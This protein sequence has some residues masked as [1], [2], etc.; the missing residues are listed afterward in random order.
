[1]HKEDQYNLLDKANKLAED[2]K[3]GQAIGI[4]RRL[5]KQGNPHAQVNLGNLLDD[6]IRPPRPVEAVNWYKRAVRAGLPEAAWCLAMHYRNLP[7]RKIRWERH[8]L[9]VAAEMGE[10]DAKREIRKLERRSGQR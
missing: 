5:A 7:S 3:V 6:E 1:M 8:W 9:K 10:P 4:L 2:G